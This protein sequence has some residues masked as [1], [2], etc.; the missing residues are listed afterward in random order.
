MI[1]YKIFIITEIIIFISL[2]GVYFYSSIKPNIEINSIWEPRGIDKIDETSIPLINT[3][4]LIS[5]ALIIT[6]SHFST[7]IKI[8]IEGMEKGIRLVLIFIILQ[9]LEYIYSSFDITSSIYGNIFFILTGLHGLHMIIGGIW[10]YIDY[11]NNLKRE[12]ENEKVILYTHFVDIL[13][14]FIFFF[15]YLL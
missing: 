13:W 6:S 3:I 10:L 8:K 15:L 1:G 2:F 5:S 14:F 11:I 12:K 4:L 7:N 9:Y